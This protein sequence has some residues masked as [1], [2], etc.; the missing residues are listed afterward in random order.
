ML[1]R[2]TEGLLIEINKSSYK[3]DHLYYKKISEIK[4]LN[5]NSNSNSNIAIINTNTPKYSSQAIDK[6]LSHF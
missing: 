4:E 5:S 1:F 3:N 6:V 2:N